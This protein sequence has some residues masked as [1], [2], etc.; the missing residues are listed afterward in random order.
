MSENNL[1]VSC[2]GATADL[3]D[4]PE[5]L[6]ALPAEKEPEPN[7]PAPGLEGHEITGVLHGNIVQFTSIVSKSFCS[8]H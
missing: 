3:E 1:R 2:S 4:L 7:G 6:T 5:H 8:V